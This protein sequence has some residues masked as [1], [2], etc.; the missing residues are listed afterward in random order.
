MGRFPCGGLFKSIVRQ[1]MELIGKTAM[2]NFMFGISG[3]AEKRGCGHLTGFGPE[4]FS[5]PLIAM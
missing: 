4:R 3:L 5:C 2:Q 1:Q